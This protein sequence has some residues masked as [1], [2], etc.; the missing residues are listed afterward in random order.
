LNEKYGAASLSIL[1]FSISSIT[2][3]N[4]SYKSYA[5]LLVD[6]PTYFS[7]PPLPPFPPPPLSPPPPAP[8]AASV[9][10]SVVSTL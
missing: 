7:A 3:F 5:F 9:T 2:F 10:S 4:I 1:L 6:E 8:P